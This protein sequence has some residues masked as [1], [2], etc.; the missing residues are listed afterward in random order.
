MPQFFVS[1]RDAGKTALVLGPFTNEESCRKYAYRP[2][3]GGSDEF[4]KVLDAVC[5]IDPKAW[6]ASF[7]M[8]MIKDGS[9]SAFLN[10]IDPSWD[11]VLS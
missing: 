1:A 7:G 5:K 6:F 2:N 4:F 3:D 9:Y 11:K 10:R 8:V